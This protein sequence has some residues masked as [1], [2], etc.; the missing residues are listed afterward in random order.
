V[1]KVKKEGASSAKLA[2]ARMHVFHEL[3]N[4][5]LNDII[6]ANERTVTVYLH[7]EPVRLQL[8]IQNLILD[9]PE[10]QKTACVRRYYDTFVLF[11]LYNVMM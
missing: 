7:G 2:S 5:I 1:P 3:Y 9:G 4:L 10:A 6:P 11:I 8:F